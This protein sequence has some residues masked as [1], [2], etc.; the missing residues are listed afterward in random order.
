MSK[1]LSIRSVHDDDNHLRLSQRG[2]SRLNSMYFN[3]YGPNFNRFMFK[4]YINRFLS[5]IK[6]G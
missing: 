1:A 4:C 3:T 2:T 5:G 6:L